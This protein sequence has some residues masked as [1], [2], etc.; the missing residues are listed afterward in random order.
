MCVD[1]EAD[2]LT[3]VMG[4]DGQTDCLTDVMGVDGQTDGLTDVIGVDDD[5]KSASDVIDRQWGSG[6]G[7]QLLTACYTDSS[8]NDDVDD[9]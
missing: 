5:A 9:N 7:L 3:D 1:H 6:S 4:V 8:D 2:G